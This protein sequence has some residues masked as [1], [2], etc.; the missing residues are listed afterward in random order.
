[1]LLQLWASRPA[2]ALLTVSLVVVWSTAT[3]LLMVS[4][5]V[6]FRPRLAKLLSTVSS[7]MALAGSVVEP[8]PWA[9]LLRLLGLTPELQLAVLLKIVLCPA[10]PSLPAAVTSVSVVEFP[11]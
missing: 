1:M 11:P 5:T 10:G 4:P 2:T 8:L 3:A 9:V 7:T 6:L